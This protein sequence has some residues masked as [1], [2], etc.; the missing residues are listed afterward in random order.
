M[1]SLC[2]TGEQ[3][4]VESPRVMLSKPKTNT[5]KRTAGSLFCDIETNSLL[6][7]IVTFQIS[8]CVLSL[9]YL[10]NILI[11][12]HNVDSCFEVSN[13]DIVAVYSL[14]QSAACIQ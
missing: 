7:I 10:Y 1:H 11:V 5:K 12:F 9:H 13:R 4:K 3:S 8:V 2:G 6:A 14:D